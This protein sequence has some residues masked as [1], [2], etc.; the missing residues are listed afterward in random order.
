MATYQKRG[1][2]WRA[3]VRRRGQTLTATFDA[4]QAAEEWAVAA[5][6]AILGGADT[7][8]ARQAQGLTIADLLDRY[9]REVSPTKRSGR[10]E[11]IKIAAM[12][13]RYP[14]FQTSVQS[15]GPDA[16]A[17]YRDVRLTQVSAYSV[18]RELNI[19]SA[20]FQ[21]ATQEWRVAAGNPVRAIRRPVNPR[22]R[23]RR[24]A[25]DERA[26]IVKALRWDGVSVP[27]CIRHWAAWAFCFGCETA[28]RQGEILR[29]TYVH[30][31]LEDG[32]IHLPMTKNGESRDVPLSS[33]ALALIALLPPGPPASRL[34]PVNAGS[35]GLEYRA[36][37]DAA[38]LHD[39]R[40]HDSRR[41][42]TTV[43]AEKLP[44]VL[45]LAA[46][47]GHKTLGV[48]KGYYAPRASDL[49]KKLG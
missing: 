1:R 40:F 11:Q 31:H 20:M 36:A 47:T 30:M 35:L 3:T 44:N 4:R 6:A 33:K 48:L 5:E 45:D 12:I 22:P 32:Y 18:N 9:S 17:R 10:W 25:Q 19:V 24:V 15:F 13:E 14:L 28:M 23:S 43:L 26:A 49:A 7:E 38:G 29:I 34:V 2:T 8:S 41:E 42:G 46:V 37:R 27:T 39:I 16:V 21:T